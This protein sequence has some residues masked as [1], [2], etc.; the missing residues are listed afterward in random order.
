MRLNEI[1]HN[2]KKWIS[3]RMLSQICLIQAN[4]YVWVSFWVKN[5]YKRVKKIYI[6]CLS[7]I[8]WPKLYFSVFILP[9][10]PLLAKIVLFCFHLRTDPLIEMQMHLKWTSPIGQRCVIHDFPHLLLYRFLQK[11]HKIDF[12]IIIF[13]SV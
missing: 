10:W 7:Q 8:F 3:L 9:L 13:K 4:L 12:F 11:S 2:Q 6:S 5:L 1:N